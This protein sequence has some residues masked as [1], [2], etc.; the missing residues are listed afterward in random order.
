M[1][2]NM[3]LEYARSVS[4][5]NNLSSN[6]LKKELSKGFPSQCTTLHLCIQG[7][8]SNTLSAITFEPQS[9]YH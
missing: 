1:K 5:L 6:L 8:V 3:P 7:P 2:Q 4:Y 9:R